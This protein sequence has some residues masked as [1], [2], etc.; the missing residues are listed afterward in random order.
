MVNITTVMTDL[1]K[2]KSSCLD[3]TGFVDPIYTNIQILVPSLPGIEQL[4][5]VPYMVLDISFNLL[6]SLTFSC[7]S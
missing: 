2:L 1:H 4:R 3:I 6:Y 7:R 5:S